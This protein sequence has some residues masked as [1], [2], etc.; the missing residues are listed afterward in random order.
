MRQAH[1]GQSCDPAD[2]PDTVKTD[3]IADPIQG[4]LAPDSKWWTTGR[5]C[6]LS[7]SAYKP[8][9][10]DHCRAPKKETKI[11]VDP[12]VR[13]HGFVDM[14]YFRNEVIHDALDQVEQA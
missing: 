8:A 11:P 10:D 4:D 7:I 2:W 5:R 12:L 9:T 6:R 13:R 3:R 1:N 14:V